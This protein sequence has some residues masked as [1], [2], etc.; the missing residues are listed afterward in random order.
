MSRGS[1]RR[2]VHIT[3]LMCNEGYKWHDTYME[4][5]TGEAPGFW[6]KK[7]FDEKAKSLARSRKSQANPN[8]KRRSKHIQKEK[9]TDYGEEAV[10]AAENAALEQSV[11]DVV[12]MRLKY[13]VIY[14]YIY[15]ICESNAIYGFFQYR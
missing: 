1:Y 12:S 3:A 11:V 6:T 2:R 5:F 14:T 10:E 8:S 13:K 9:E 15:V 4:M 7:M